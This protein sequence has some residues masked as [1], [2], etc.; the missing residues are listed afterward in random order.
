[1][2]TALSVDYRAENIWA[3]QAPVRLSN[4]SSFEA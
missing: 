3:L 2:T 4:E 1:M